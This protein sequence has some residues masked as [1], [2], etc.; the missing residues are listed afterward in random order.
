MGK[1]LVAKSARL[2]AVEGRTTDGTAAGRV[3]IPWVLSVA[4]VLF[5]AASE[6]STT[7]V[8]QV[9]LSSLSLTAVAWGG[10]ILIADRK[11]PHQSLLR[12]GPWMLAYGGITFG[13]AS[14][15]A[16]LSPESVSPQVQLDAF[17]AAHALVIFGFIAFIIG[18]LFTPRAGLH[19]LID[20]GLSRVHRWDEGQGLSL[21]SALLT[22]LLG[23]GALILGAVMSGNYGYL[24]DATVT[25]AADVSWY[26]QGLVILSSLR[27]FAIMAL[28]VAMIQRNTTLRVLLAV[29]VTAVD[30]TAG[31][32]SGMKEAPLITLIAIVLAY[33]YAKRRLPLLALIAIGS[34]FTLFLNPLV[35]SLR[36]VV[37]DNGSLPLQDALSAA[38]SKLLQ[39]KVGSGDDFRLAV[40]RFRLIDNM[41]IINQKTPSEIP[42][43]PVWDLATQAL[44]GFIPRAIWPTK[45]VGVEGLLFYRDYYGG[46]TYISA[47]L[48]IPGSL[49]MFGGI[50]VL[51]VGMALFGMLTRSLDDGMRASDSRTG[52]LLLLALFPSFIKM[53]F[54]APSLLVSLP[55]AGIG[56]LLA[57]WL[58][59]HPAQKVNE[60][61]RPLDRQRTMPTHEGPTRSRI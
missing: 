11:L 35:T 52:L 12:L 13:L 41:A 51:V 33:M 6:W 5:W 56:W 57:S 58:L 55:A 18:Y 48:T 47:A 32:L 40:S 39:A 29:A 23:L 3:A 53:E 44:S 60:A 46:T 37:R 26:T 21:P 10:A 9:A 34:G 59:Y 50:I 22:Y 8:Q 45:P 27:G 17:R 49:Y 24:G 16:W 14:V 43:R 36:R 19:R 7:T 15:T 25:S 31:L 20:S 4:A 2:A 30:L 1:P 38:S 54:G 42:F 61:R 28:W